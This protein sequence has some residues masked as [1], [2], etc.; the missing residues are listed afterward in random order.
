MILPPL[1]EVARY[2]GYRHQ[3]TDSETE[4]VIHQC[5]KELNEVIQPRTYARE[6]PLSF[7]NETIL[8]EGTAIPSHSLYRNLKGC[9]DVLLF[10]AT[11][12]HGSDLLIRKT[13]VTS[14]ARASILQAAASAM[15]EEVC[16]QENRRL[17]EQYKAKGLYL[18]PRFSP[19]Y[20]DLPLETQ[21]LF[22]SLLD[23]Y[24]NAGISL[25]ESLL[26]SPSKSVTAFIGISPYQERC[27]VKGCT[28]C[29]HQ[30][31]CMFYKEES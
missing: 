19:G 4:T 11:L 18:R 12:G 27:A 22:F 21:R 20:G 6:F 30:D 29:S 17:E 16:D 31:S 9:T 13:T 5:L 24:R 1:K 10:C 28:L 2:L 25:S 8:L 26:M 23:P 3:E 15:I 7:D 14:M